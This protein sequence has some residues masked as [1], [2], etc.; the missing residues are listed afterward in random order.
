M[1]DRRGDTTY[2]APAAPDSY[3]PHI[4]ADRVPG[5]HPAG[6]GRERKR[7]T[8]V[9]FHGHRAAHRHDCAAFDGDNGAARHHDG[10]AHDY[11]THHWDGAAFDDHYSTSHDGTAHGHDGTA[12]RHDDAAL[13]G[14]YGTEA[15]RD[16]NWCSNTKR[17]ELP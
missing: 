15:Q 13:G 17:G 12:Y 6:D 16:G 4:P 3:P 11:S 8:G 14:D 9:T 2:S 10:A 7:G 5:A 1:T